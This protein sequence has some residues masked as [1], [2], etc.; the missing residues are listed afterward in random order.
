MMIITRSR[1]AKHQKYVC[2]F[3]A[4]KTQALLGAYRLIVIIFPKTIEAAA[5]HRGS[6]NRQE[7]A[8][9]TGIKGLQV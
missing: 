4:R 3:A 9:I 1:A 2:E 5:A 8:G 7:S 6:F